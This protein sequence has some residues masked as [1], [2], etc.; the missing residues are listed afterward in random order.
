MDP[1]AQ[2]CPWIVLHGG[3]LFRSAGNITGQESSFPVCWM[4]IPWF[5]SHRAIGSVSSAI[6]FF[7]IEPD[8]YEIPKDGK[9]IQKFIL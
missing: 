2:D 7:K 5:L 4:E 8:E 6:D 1:S 3:S 9:L